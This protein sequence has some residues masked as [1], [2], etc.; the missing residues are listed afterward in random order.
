MN[1]II[2]E[3]CRVAE[4]KEKKIVIIPR[5]KNNGRMSREND[6]NNWNVVALHLF[7]RIFDIQVG[8]CRIECNNFHENYQTYGWVFPFYF[9][10]NFFQRNCANADTIIIGFS[11]ILFTAIRVWM[12]YSFLNCCTQNDGQIYFIMTQIVLAP[13]KLNYSH[14]HTNRT[15]SFFFLH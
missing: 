10:E 6:L 9:K 5:H 4:N 3:L 15:I 1:E 13:R 14:N 12:V 8:G 2:S 7:Y 11:F